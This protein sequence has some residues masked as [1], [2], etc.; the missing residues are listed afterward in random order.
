MSTITTQIIKQAKLQLPIRIKDL[1]YQFNHVYDWYDEPL[2]YSIKTVS[3]DYYLVSAYA[4]YDQLDN[5]H[6]IDW[7]VAF[8]VAK[9]ELMCLEQRKLTLNDLYRNTNA[10]QYY[11][12]KDQ[13]DYSDQEQIKSDL[14]FYLINVA[15]NKPG[16]WIDQNTK[17]LL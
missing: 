16:W 11:L 10:K 3:N 14:T 12:I 7:Q 5:Q 9:A 6:E 15:D 13:I 2:L 1:H 4:D 8:P 17:V